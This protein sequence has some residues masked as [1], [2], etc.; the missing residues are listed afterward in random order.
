MT[1]GAPFISFV[2]PVYN[3]GENIIAQLQALQRASDLHSHEVIIVYDQ[4]TDNTLPVLEQIDP[5]IPSLRVIKNNYGHGARN[6]LRTGFASARGVGVCVTMA[7]LSDDLRL[8]PTMEAL[9]GEGV[10]LVSPSRYM[11]GG[12]QIGGPWLKR[13]LSSLAGRSLFMLAGLP[14]H[15]P[16]NNFKLYRTSMLRDLALEQNGG[17]EIALEITVKAHR[18]G[19]RIEELPATWKDRPAGR[20]NFRLWRWLPRYIKW[21]L[22]CLLAGRPGKASSGRK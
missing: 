2:I 1:A 8:L 5:M 20:S 18:A 7:D 12:Q 6:A 9:L 15:D 14:T 10:D 11:P 4:E 13:T 21:Y 19:Y 17:F 3:E 16:T 22:V